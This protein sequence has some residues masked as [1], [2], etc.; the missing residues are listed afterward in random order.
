VELS[1]KKFLAT[2]SGTK[3]VIHIRDEIGPDWA[4]M[5]SDETIVAFLNANPKLDTLELQINSPGGDCFTA[6]AIYNILKSSGAFIDVYIDSLAAS[7]ASLV[8]MAGDRITIAKNAMVMIH[9]CWAVCVGSEKDL[10]AQI[11]IMKTIDNNLVDIY[12]ERTGQSKLQIRSWMNAES[13]FDANESVK[14]GFA[15]QTGLVSTAK[16]CVAAGRYRNTPAALLSNEKFPRRA[17][18]EKWLD[19]NVKHP[20]AAAARAAAAELMEF[21]RA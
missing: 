11:P 2:V 4:G 3:G 9:L 20:R 1:E 13:W 18:L 10:A 19:E 21:A 7:A 15:D 17:A 5:I 12:A 8:A 6:M 16:A 14:Y